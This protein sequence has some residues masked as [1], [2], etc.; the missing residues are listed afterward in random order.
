MSPSL[1]YAWFCPL[2]SSLQPNRSPHSSSA[3]LAASVLSSSQGA[4]KEEGA[5]VTEQRLLQ[6]QQLE[7]M[8][9]L[10]PITAIS[11]PRRVAYTSGAVNRGAGLR[12][13]ADEWGDFQGNGAAQHGSHG[14]QVED[15]SA[16]DNVSSA[17]D[18]EARGAATANP[19]H[20]VRSQDVMRCDGSSGNEEDDSSPSTV[21]NPLVV[22][23]M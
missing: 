3:N 2:C 20:G 17:V 11:A 14:S 8:K 1:S 18:N 7:K 6:Q 21:T 15:L 4:Q 23:S 13:E 10:P 19:L 16:S 9:L 22:H 12:A 5:M